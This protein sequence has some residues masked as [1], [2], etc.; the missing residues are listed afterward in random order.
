MKIVNCAQGSSE[1]FIARSGRVTASEVGGAVS[2]LKRGDK[3]GG[4]TAARAAYRSRIV[5][6]TLLGAPM[7]DGFVSTYMKYGTEMEPFARA[8][9]E[10]RFD[11]EVA[12]VGFVIHPQ[13]DRSGAS[14][15]GLVGEDGGVELK[16]PKTETHLGYMLAG[17]LPPEYEPQVMWNMACTGREWWDFVSFDGRMPLRHQLFRMRVMRDE[18]RIAEL[19]EGVIQFLADVDTTLGQLET[20]NPQEEAPAKAENALGIT[21][22]DIASW[23]AQHPQFSQR[24]V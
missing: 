15:D 14:P 19:E 2:F 21:D 3:K 4:E 23:Y 5:A 6:E 24:G 8:A 17:V 7:M 10:V 20:I 22:A 18:Q 9:Y 1:W 16:C 11:L 12:Q 13:I